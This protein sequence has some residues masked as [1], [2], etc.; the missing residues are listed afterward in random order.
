MGIRAE[1]VSR[2]HRS[3]WLMA[4]WLETRTSAALVETDAGLVD[5]GLAGAALPAGAAAPA[6]GASLVCA[7]P[8][9]PRSLACVSMSCGR[10]RLNTSSSEGASCL[11]TTSYAAS[12]APE[13][14]VDISVSKRYDSW[15]SST[16][17]DTSGKVIVPLTSEPSSALPDHESV[18]T[19]S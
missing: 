1:L 9:W 15:L 17:W 3:A 4:S 12:V 16:S 8:S 5:A 13:E 18:T 7:S 19:Q 14:G 10:K 11:R 2:S 6:A